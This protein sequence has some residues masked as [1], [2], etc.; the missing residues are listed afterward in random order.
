MAWRR[1]SCEFGLLTQSMLWGSHHMKALLLKKPYLQGSTF[2]DHP[3]MGAALGRPLL[4][5]T[6]RLNRTPTF[7]SA[8]ELGG[9]KGAAALLEA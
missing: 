7:T 3:Y 6:L 9:N 4:P 1:A 8:T 2:S 5:H